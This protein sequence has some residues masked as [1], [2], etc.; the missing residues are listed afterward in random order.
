MITGMLDWLVRVFGAAFMPHGHCYL[1][2]PSMVWLQVLSNFAIG[3][4]YVSISAT[5]YYIIRRIRDLP[6]SCMYLAFGVFIVTCGGTHFMDVVTIWIPIYWLDGGLRAVT[7]IASVGTAIMLFPLVPKAV[8]L[9]DA[10]AV[11]HDRGLKL[12]QAYKDLAL[13]HERATELE[14]LKTRFF[15]NVSHELRT[16]L[17]LILG[18]VERLVGALLLGTEERRDLE[19]V[20]RNARLLLRHVN[21]LL[22]AAKIEAGRI[23]PNYVKADVAELVRVQASLFESRAREVGFGFY[24]EAPP[25][26]PAEIDV[27]MIQRVIVN[28]LSNAVKH[29]PSDG[30][31]RVLVKAWNENLTI[32]VED[33]GVGIPDDLK[34]VIF[35]RF[36]QAEG[37]APSRVGGT[38]LGLAIVKDFVELHRGSVRVEDAAGGG[39][40]FVV[41]LPRRA[42]E[43]TVAA[44][45][46]ALPA[47][48]PPA[49]E[50]LEA[51]AGEQPNDDESSSDDHRLVLLVVEDNADMRRF[52]RSA[53]E[54]TFRVVTA[55][56]GKEALDRAQVLRPD[57]IVTDMMMPRMNG[58]EL[59][60]AIR[61]TAELAETPMV[62]LTARADQASRIDVLRKG[63]NDYIVKPF[64]IEELRLRVGNLLELSRA[65]SLLRGELSE[66]RG[67]AADLAK[68]LAARARELALAVEEAHA[69]AEDA[70]RAGQIKT[71]FLNLLSH[72]IRTPITTLQVQTEL[73]R[74]ASVP[75]RELVQ[76]GVARMEVSLARLAD[77]L[78]ALLEWANLQ[79]GVV[80]PNRVQI[81]LGTLVRAVTARHSAEAKLKGLEFEVD[82]AADVPP[83]V[84]DPSLVQL[85]VL[86]LVS[87][88][89]KY[90]EHG[91]VRVA[92][93]FAKGE[94]RVDVED[95]GRGITESQQR[96]IFEAF[97]H[98]EPIA[99]K[100][101]PGVGLGL[102]IARRVVDVLG[103]RIELRSAPGTGS[104]FSTVF[105]EVAG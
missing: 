5:L 43:G 13:V 94:H 7:A 62:V 84:N 50:A 17:T 68:A 30:T 103:G 46:A 98:L 54:P 72:E 88:A 38:G 14:R 22:D 65:R 75:T 3:A 40:S 49:F 79:S 26:L 101:T 12:E 53:L 80:S 86:N 10:A 66:A 102:A 11:A 37:D 74:R 89:V 33:T 32:R 57:L 73:L 55:A 48:T 92:V 76:K 8:A 64:S 20:L 91:R 45:L 77:Q 24:V 100:H 16:P 23:A 36:R 95:T 82:V 25:T 60:A 51:H 47:V 18:P 87:N 44:E 52:T 78:N 19:V 67:D 97:E 41:R 58:E 29:V 39:A 96:I 56:D 69:S 42:P 70:T 81:D 4:A 83:L 27:D 61:A 9:A 31:V 15:A 34:T 85:V 105:A 90:T 93:S 1:W 21:D 2:S 28:L 35:E 99:E 71:N 6:F 104:T 63:A 59:V